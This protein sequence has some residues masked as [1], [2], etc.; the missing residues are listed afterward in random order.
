MGQFTKDAVGVWESEGGAPAQLGRPSSTIE[1]AVKQL[2]GT[3]DQIE[4][5]ERIRA[6][7]NTEFDRVANVMKSSAAKQVEPDRTDTEAV[8]AILEEKRAE[9]MARNEAG[10]FIHDWQQ[11]GDQ[12]RQMILHDSRYLA[13]KGNKAAREGR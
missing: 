2:T 3:I 8:I 4:W 7:V 13:M 12:V 5:A 10:Y 1:P 9:V 11:S 6:R